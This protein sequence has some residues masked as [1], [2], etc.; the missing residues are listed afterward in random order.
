MAEQGTEVGE[1]PREGKWVEGA[2]AALEAHTASCGL[3]CEEPGTAV[4]H[5][6]A[7]LLEYCDALGVDLDALLHDAR[8]NG[9]D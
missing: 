7:S 9:R 2:R 1:D 4:W 6:L 3:V 8:M 5:L